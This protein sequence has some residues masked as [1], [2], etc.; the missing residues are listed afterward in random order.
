M[1]TRSV[2]ILPDHFYHLYNRGNNKQSIFRT[3]ENFRFFL[4]TFRKYFSEERIRLVAYCLMP[5]HFH[6]LILILQ[7]FDF[8]NVMRSF[9]TSY[10][11]SFHSWHKTSGH[12]FED[13]YQAKLIRDDKHLIEVIPYIHL[14]PVIARLVQHPEEWEFSDC[15]VWCQDRAGNEIRKQFYGSAASYRRYLNQYA[16]RKREIQA[17][18]RRL[19]G[20]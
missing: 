11:K 8:S 14:N 7:K 3:R 20:W 15:N 2:E 17:L 16:T 10:V 13:D 12:L 4:R 18:E 1:G 6:L 19:L 5:N 9:S